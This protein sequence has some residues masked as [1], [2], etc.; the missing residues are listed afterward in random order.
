VASAVVGRIPD[1]RSLFAIFKYSIYALL[2]LNAFLFFEEEFFA[3]AITYGD[4]LASSQVVEAFAATIDTTAWIVLLL[5]FELQ[6]SVIRDETLVGVRKWTL[7]AVS[8][9]CYALILYSFWG[10]VA[11]LY[12]LSSGFAPFP[13]SDVCN[14]AGGSA[15]LAMGLDEYVPLGAANC[16]TIAGAHLYRL[17]AQPVYAD[18]ASVSALLRLCWVD[19]INAA[20]W[21]GVVVVLEA[22]VWQQK[23]DAL[24]EHYLWSSRVCK[25]ILYGA[26]LAAG[27]YWGFLGDF[28]DF[29]DA[30]LWL[31]A[32]V[33]IE[34]NF[35][36]WR[37][38]EAEV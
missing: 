24:S 3:S 34:M 27:I 28:V 19:V 18:A 7:R 38:E 8:G 11:K 32:F 26:L 4:G 35:F 9:L 5:V 31:V 6:T 30:A 36:E 25:A 12:T 1:S 17:G 2:C 33:F 21:L 16:Q 23:R 15:S 37:S 29:W 10:Y 22:D 13:V 20:A 14:L